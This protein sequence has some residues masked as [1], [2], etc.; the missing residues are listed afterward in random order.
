MNKF[1]QVNS[2][3]GKLLVRPGFIPNAPNALSLMR[4]LSA[5]RSID[6]T[7]AGDERCRENGAILDGAR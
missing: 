1:C 5:P 4:L 3:T 6:R 2:L 7:D